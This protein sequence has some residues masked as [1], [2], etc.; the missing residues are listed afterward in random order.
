MGSNHS[1]IQDEKLPVRMD[2]YPSDLKPGERQCIPLISLE[3]LRKTR[4]FTDSTAELKSKLDEKNVYK[5]AT[6]LVGPD[7]ESTVFHGFDY[8][9]QCPKLILDKY[10]RIAYVFH[11]YDNNEYYPVEHPIDENFDPLDSLTSALSGTHFADSGLDAHQ[12]DVFGRLVV[13]IGEVIHGDAS[14]VRRIMVVGPYNYGLRLKYANISIKIKCSEALIIFCNEMAKIFDPSQML[15]MT[16]SE[17]YTTR[18]QLEDDGSIVGT[19]K[20]TLGVVR[21]GGG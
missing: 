8:L 4:R 6:A 9:E 12:R 13:S 18:V 7:N 20:W 15:L 21:N 17:G 19:P 10:V 11:G 1:S 5:W 14:D 2:E 3:T 16:N